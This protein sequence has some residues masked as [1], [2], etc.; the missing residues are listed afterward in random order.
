MVPRRIRGPG[1]DSSLSYQVL[2][3]VAFTDS[4]NEQDTGNLPGD[5]FYS[6]MFAPR[7]RGDWSIWAGSLTWDCSRLNEADIVFACFLIRRPDLLHLLRI[8][9]A[10]LGHLGLERRQPAGESA[11][12]SWCWRRGTAVK[13]GSTS[14]IAG[15]LPPGSMSG[16]FSPSAPFG[17]APCGSERRSRTKPQP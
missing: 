14:P 3:S 17:A 1:D 16:S 8:P 2:V 11:P 10:R 4:P 12:R 6:V 15:C 13:T 9:D 7:V 5:T